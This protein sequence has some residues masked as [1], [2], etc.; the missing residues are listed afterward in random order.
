MLYSGHSSL[1]YLILK[2][3]NLKM[4][5]HSQPASALFLDFFEVNGESRVRLVYK[6][7]PSSEEKVL[8][9][10]QFARD[11]MSL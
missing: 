6:E 4:M 3:F 11:S 1:A 10:K 2:I 9:V 8:K 5:E 7:D